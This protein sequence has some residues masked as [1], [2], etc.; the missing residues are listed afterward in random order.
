MKG[1]R[2]WFATLRVEKRCGLMHYVA[3]FTDG[4]LRASLYG[5]VNPLTASPSAL[6]QAAWE[7]AIEWLSHIQRVP[8]RPLWPVRRVYF[9]K[10]RSRHKQGFGRAAAA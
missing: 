10:N 4:Q 2:R 9:T 6:K 1:K 3:E 7:A 8:K 5:S